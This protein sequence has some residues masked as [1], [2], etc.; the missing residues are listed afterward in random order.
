MPIEP[1][2]IKVHFSRGKNKVKGC[3]KVSRERSIK[4][5]G[6]TTSKKAEVLTSM[7]TT[8]GPTKAT[9]Q[10]TS[11]TAKHNSFIQTVPISKAT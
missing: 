2:G 9:G 4:V 5:N 7:P 3:Y 1:V 8:N 6:R 10:T 11:K